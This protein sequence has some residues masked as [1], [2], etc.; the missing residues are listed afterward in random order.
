MNDD[1]KAMHVGRE[2]IRIE[3]LA[4]AA[5]AARINGDFARRDPALQL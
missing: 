4:V 3:H 5:L 1:E 2:V